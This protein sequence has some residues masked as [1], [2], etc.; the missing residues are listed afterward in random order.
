MMQRSGAVAVIIAAGLVLLAGVAY[1]FVQQGQVVARAGNERLTAAQFQKHYFPYLQKTGVADS[2]SLRNQFAMD[3]MLSRLVI[4]NALEAGVAEMPAYRER[5]ERLRRALLTEAYMYQM[6]WDTVEVTDA[7]VRAM[8]LRS[9]TE[10]TARHLYATTKSGAT[11]L[12]NRLLAGET[13]E[14]LASEVFSDSRLLNTGGYLGAFSFDEMDW[15]LEDVAFTMPIGSISE[16]IRTAQGYSILKVESRLTNPLI[17]EWAFTE[18]RRVFEAYTLRRRRE[19]A[20][21]ETLRQILVESRISIDAGVL[22]ALLGQIDGSAV[23]DQ[24]ALTLL[25]RQPYATFT[26]ESQDRTWSVGDFRGRAQQ[27]TAQRRAAVRTAEDLIAFTQGLIVNEV[28][29]DRARKLRLHRTAAFSEAL[30]NALDNYILE[31]SRASISSG[32][33]VHEDS[34]RAYFDRAP[35]MEFMRPASVYV[36]VARENGELAWS[37]QVT[38]ADLGPWTDTVFSVEE[39]SVVGPLKAPAGMF[40]VRVGAVRP[41]GRMSFDEARPRVTNILRY[42][43]TRKA[44]RDLYNKL[45]TQNEILIFNSRLSQVEL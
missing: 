6:V 36:E 28:L 40:M 12:R 35:A 18:K 38:S 24:E 16:P 27:V 29:V 9:H 25:M 31:Q 39:G 43:E 1:Y 26:Q 3:L 2:Q 7:E 10:V 17:T 45:R 14:S 5:A 8:Y 21:K 15:A 32:I 22:E 11:N 34:I 4:A 33:V 20:R 30:T 44:R 13:F 23:L 42:E 41:A 37:G 19:R